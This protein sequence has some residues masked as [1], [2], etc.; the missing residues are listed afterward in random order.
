MLR[1]NGSHSNRELYDDPVSISYLMQC[2]AFTKDVI[3]ELAYFYSIT[4][5]GQVGPGLQSHQPQTVTV[6]IPATKPKPAGTPVLYT[7]E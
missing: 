7:L 4:F 2:P 5:S 6:Q 3:G 1:T